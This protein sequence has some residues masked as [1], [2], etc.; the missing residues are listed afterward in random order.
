MA[1]LS[2]ALPIFDRCE[3]PNTASVRAC[4]LQPGR[5]AQGP[6]EKCGLDGRTPGIAFVMVSILPDRRPSV[7]R[8]FPLAGLKEGRGPR[9]ALQTKSRG[10]I[11]RRASSQ[12]TVQ[13]AAGSV[14]DVAKADPDFVR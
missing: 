10:E 6:E 4:R 8:G 9:Q 3:R 11:S 13:A 12:K 1:R 2:F 5:L 7:G 14:Q